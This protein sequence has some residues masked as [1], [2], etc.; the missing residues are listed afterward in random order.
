MALYG[1]LIIQAIF[2]F[3]VDLC[4]KEE[5]DASAVESLSQYERIRDMFNMRYR[6]Y[7]FVS[8]Y[9]CDPHDRRYLLFAG[10]ASSEQLLTF[11]V[12]FL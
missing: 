9:L 5:N 7:I 11:K 4:D 6:K 10:E 3:A 1:M 8:E 12:Y 2:F